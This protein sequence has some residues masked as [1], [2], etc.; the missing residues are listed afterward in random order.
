MMK[1]TNTAPKRHL[2]W[3]AIE[4]DYRAGIKTLRQIAGEHGLTHG[5]INKHAKA[6]GW[7]R[8]LN[9]RIAALAQAKVAKAVSTESIA[10][11]NALVDEASDLV[12]SAILGQRR[13]VGRARGVVRRLFGELEGLMDNVTDLEQMA[14]IL[15]DDDG[16][17]MQDL[18]RKVTALPSKTDVAKKLSESLRVL[19]ELER[20]VLRIKDEAEQ[21]T[22]IEDIL[23]AL[24]RAG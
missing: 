15:A 6:A 13:D 16:G 8:D 1:T 9:A 12:A 18:L 3:R 2:D 21:Q 17:A 20:K 4:L 22:S 19:V 14:N 7:S 23:L 24:D 10:T 11:E 5:A